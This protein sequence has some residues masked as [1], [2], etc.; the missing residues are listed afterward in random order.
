[1]LDDLNDLNNNFD[2]NNEIFNNKISPLEDKF[3]Q[4][5][6][7]LNILSKTIKDFS[8]NFSQIIPSEI[9][10]N[11][12]ILN[13]Q[14]KTL[15]QTVNDQFLSLIKN[16]N[17]VTDGLQ[18]KI[19]S[20]EEAL[21]DTGYKLNNLLALT[22]KYENQETNI[23]D[24]RLQSLSLIRELSQTLNDHINSI[25]PHTSMSTTISQLQEEVKNQELQNNSLSTYLENFANNFN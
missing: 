1:M 3:K 5:E 24:Y 10:N 20:N 9:E 25:S 6:T 18:N 7:Q 4:N 8:S 12:K 22:P 11:L 2:L 19:I 23:H 14:Q 21:H 16:F 17:L 13:S 15:T